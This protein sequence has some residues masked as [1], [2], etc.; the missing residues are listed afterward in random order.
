MLMSFAVATFLGP[1]AGDFGLLALRLAHMLLAVS[2]AVYLAYRFAF[3]RAVIA[4]DPAKWL[5]G[6]A[7]SGFIWTARGDI[8]QAIGEFFLVDAIA[9]PLT[10]N[11]GTVVLTLVNGAFAI[12][13]VL[14][15]VCVFWAGAAFRLMSGKSLWRG[16]PLEW[17]SFKFALEGI[18]FLCVAFYMAIVNAV[19]FDENLLR[20]ALKL[21]ATERDALPSSICKN[22]RPADR[23]LFLGPPYDNVLV[24][25]PPIEGPYLGIDRVKQY[26]EFTV[27]GVRKCARGDAGDDAGL[28]TG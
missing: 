19:G 3:V 25:T 21:S 1:S 16:R 18:I 5:A 6:I 15:S 20:Y 10:L 22:V 2:Y 26:P 14:T 27:Q 4:W 13:A 8:S 23:V 28:A 17:L 12:C 9:L 24:I 11:A 7:L